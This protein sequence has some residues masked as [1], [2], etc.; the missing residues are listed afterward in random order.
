MSGSRGGGEPERPAVVQVRRWQGEGKRAG[1]LSEVREKG[2]M[3]LSPTEE[4][5]VREKGWVEEGWEGKNVPGHLVSLSKGV[6]GMEGMQSLPGR[7]VGM[8][9]LASHHTR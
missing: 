9:D 3:S 6:R 8:A 2:C 7:T 4:V 5:A 1:L